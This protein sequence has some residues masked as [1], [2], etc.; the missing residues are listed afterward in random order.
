[1]STV[2]TLDGS[3][4]YLNTG[5][6]FQSTH[7]GSF[8]WSCWVKLDDGQP[9]A[10]DTILGTSIG[11]DIMMINA[12]TTGKI[13]FRFEGENDNASY[14]TNAAVFS[15]GATDWTHIT[16][17]ATYNAGGADTSF[18]IYVNGSVVAGTLTGSITDDNHLLWTTTH[19]IYLGGVNNTGTLNNAWAGN[20][21]E[22]ALWDVVLDADAVAAIYAAGRSYDLTAD[23]GN[24]D[25][26]S[27]LTGYWRMGEGSNDDLTN[28]IIFDQN[29]STIGSN[30][31]TESSF[32]TT[33]DWTA[34]T[35]SGSTSAVSTDIAHTGTKSWK[36]TVDGT[37]T[38]LGVTQDVTVELN[39]VYR[40]D[41]WCYAHADNDAAIAMNM[42]KNAGNSIAF[43]GTGASYYSNSIPL[44]VWT[45]LTGYFRTASSN[46]ALTFKVGQ[47]GTSG[48]AGDIFYV[49]DVTLVKIGGNPGIAAA[50]ATFI[51]Q[52]V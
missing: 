51:R 30:L 39:T 22:V 52:P 42:K 36:V 34:V 32:E 35:A 38:N 8:S 49:D 37:D 4:D 6:T 28:G 45:L 24:Y 15:D 23:T 10:D 14:E 16:C 27:D 47:G 29:T 17:T 18:A 33:D 7:R 31:I 26:A 21:D 41:V 44:G 2:M 20:M 11:T 9:A 13:E 50:N 3:G 19:N 46:T 5:S 12:R 40:A 48:A 25:N 1:M 43:L